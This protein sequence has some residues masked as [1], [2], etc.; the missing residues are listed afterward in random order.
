M[1]IEQAAVGI[2][3][4]LLVSVFAS[5][6]SGRLGVPTLI[7]FLLL[8]MLAGSEGIGGIAFDDAGMAQRLGVL[9]LVFILFAGGAETDWNHIRGVAAPA[10]ALATVGVLITALIVGWFAHLV[11]DLTLIEGLLLGAIVSST[12]AAAVFSILRSRGVRM[13]RDLSGLL[14]L[15]SGSNDPMAVFLTTA[16]LQAMLNPSSSISDAAIAFVQQMTFGAAAGVLA[17]FV[18][19]RLI[20]R[21]H[22]EY[23]GLYPV[24]TIAM[25]LFTYGATS[26]IGGNGFL[27]VYLLGVMMAR[28]NYVQ[29]RTLTRFHDGIAWL[30]QIAMFVTL[31]LLVFPSQLAP[32]A[33]VSLA[34]AAVLMLVARPVAVFLTLAPTRFAFAEKVLISWVGL[35][36]AVPIILATFPLVAGI[37]ASPLIFNIVFFIV[38]ASVLLQ[39]ASIAVVARKLG[40]DEAQSDAPAESVH[41]SG[42][43][44]S[45][46]VTLEVA[47]GSRGDGLRV[48]ELGWPR[49]TL[50]LIVYRGTEFFVPNGATQIFA[51]DRLIVLTSKATVDDLRQCVGASAA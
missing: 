14:E 25:V 28:E 40:L 29:R 46:L 27:A 23:Q 9:A 5:K 43:G 44:E 2:A 36:G 26:E 6:A 30:M 39:G 32:V 42:R 3:I 10:G 1:T 15:E 11:A 34:I 7:A 38:F 21:A 18:A 50:I 12:D 17:G 20:N 37:P 47:P 49:E 24:L 41:L 33:G 19:V 16:V 45:S 4:L 35:R 8:G 13:R 22:L 31:G 51:G 48:V